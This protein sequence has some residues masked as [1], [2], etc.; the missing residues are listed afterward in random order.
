MRED[1]ET[2]HVKVSEQEN[3]VLEIL[4]REN[5]KLFDH[6]LLRVKSQDYLVRTKPSY[7]NRF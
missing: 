7:I 5:D 1:V 2:K 6:T 4:K 3:R